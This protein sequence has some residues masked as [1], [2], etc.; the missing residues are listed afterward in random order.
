[1]ICGILGLIFALP[2]AGP[3]LAIVFGSMGKKQIAASEGREGGQSMAS[4][5]VVMGWIGLPLNLIG[6]ALF[7]LVFRAVTDTARDVIENLP[8]ILPTITPT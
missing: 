6:I 3:I 8:S 7:F 5:G 2:V 4:S 1:M